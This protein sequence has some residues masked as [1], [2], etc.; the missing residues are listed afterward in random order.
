LGIFPKIGVWG[1]FQPGSYRAILPKIVKK[2]LFLPIFSIFGQNAGKTRFLG[3]FG[4]KRAILAFFGL[5]T[6]GFY[7][8]PSRR[9]PAVPGGGG[10]PRRGVGGVPPPPSGGR[11]VRPE[12]VPLGKPDAGLLKVIYYY[13]RGP[14]RQ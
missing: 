14:G 10:S 9:G 2:W 11:V 13:S 7:I 1:S 4:Q 8:N 12:T 6:Q 3:L 5:P